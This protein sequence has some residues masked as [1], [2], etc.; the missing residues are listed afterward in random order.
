MYCPICRDP[1]DDE[2]R[3]PFSYD[4]RSEKNINDEKKMVTLSCDHHFHE[5]CIRIWYERSDKCPVCCEEIKIDTMQY[6][7]SFIVHLE[8]D[9]QDR[10]Y[11]YAIKPFLWKVLVRSGNKITFDKLLSD[12]HNEL[13]ENRPDILYHCP[14]K[15]D[16]LLAI[17][18]EEYEC[19]MC[20]DCVEY[21]LP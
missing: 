1:Y 16:L 3:T 17:M 6:T 9:V 4:T 5:R 8:T 2:I 13:Q 12:T 15:L 11:K 10:R 18:N 14:L 19:H 21:T 20:G 7:S